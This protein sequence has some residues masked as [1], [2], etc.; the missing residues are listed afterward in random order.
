MHLSKLSG[1]VPAL[2]LFLSAGAHAQQLVQDAGTIEVRLRAVT[3]IPEVNSSISPIGGHAEVDI[4]EIPELDGTYFLTPNWALELIAGVTQHNAHAV[5]TAIGT[6]DLGSTWLL[7]PTL[8]LQYHY[9]AL[10]TLDLYAG[11]G[12]NYT[13]FL[14]NSLPSNGLVKSISYDNNVGEALQAGFDF[15]LSDRWVLNLDVKQLFLNTTVKVNGAVKANV[16]VN[17]TLVGV[18]IGYRF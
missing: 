16:D 10:P 12:L 4:N 8:T 6:V 18:G 1:I 7:P 9:Q 13:F 17:P 14:G 15:A 11:A 2:L 5:G 3:V